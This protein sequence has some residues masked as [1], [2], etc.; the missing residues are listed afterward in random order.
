MV[1][2]KPHLELLEPHGTYWNG[3]DPDGNVV[4]VDRNDI[5]NYD[6]GI[7]LAADSERQVSAIRRFGTEAIRAVVTCGDC[8]QGL[9]PGDLC[10]HLGV[11]TKHK[12]YEA[13]TW[14]YNHIGIKPRRKNE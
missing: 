13:G 6:T 11:S 2:E 3:V 7:E 5:G 10:A 8:G 12:V 4:P 9:G 1:Q 14:G